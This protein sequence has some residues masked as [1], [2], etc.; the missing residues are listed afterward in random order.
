M[1]KIFT[2]WLILIFSKSF[3]QSKN[4]IDQAYLETETE[5]DSLIVPDRIYIT[6]MLNESDTK[7]RK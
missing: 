1:N 4:F 5:V 2:L 7:N 3:S 6:I